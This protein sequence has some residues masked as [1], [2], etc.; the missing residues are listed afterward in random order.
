MTLCVVVC[1]LG[2]SLVGLRWTTEFFIS[3]C[4]LILCVIAMNE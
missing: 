2:N 4:E 3:P 1:Y